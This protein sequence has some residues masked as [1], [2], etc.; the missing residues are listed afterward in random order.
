MR[1]VTEVPR[2]ADPVFTSRRRSR[3]QRPDL[4]V[5]AEPATVAWRWQELPN[6]T[7]TRLCWGLLHR[8]QSRRYQTSSSLRIQLR[9][10]DGGVA[11]R[12]ISDLERIA[13]DRFTRRSRGVG[14]FHD[15]RGQ[16]G[17]DDLGRG[18]RCWIREPSKRRGSR[19]AEVRLFSCWRVK[20]DGGMDGGVCWLVARPSRAPDRTKLSSGNALVL[21]PLAAA[22]VHV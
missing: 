17:G 19:P 20:R 15:C 5:K 14:R 22:S 16:S 6:P 21:L 3:R 10:W 12:R 2:P 8:L 4:R 18:V 7:S 9:G 1:V 13:A 11:C